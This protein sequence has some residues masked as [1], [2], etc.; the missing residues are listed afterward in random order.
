MLLCKQFVKAED[1]SP[2]PMQRITTFQ[3]TVGVLFGVTE[4]IVTAQLVKA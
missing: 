3:C 2:I 4:F 1:S